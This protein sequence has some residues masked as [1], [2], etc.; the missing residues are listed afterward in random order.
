M[1]VTDVERLAPRQGW[2]QR[3]ADRPLLLAAIGALCISSSGVLVELAASGAATTAFFR[4]ALALPFLV[5]LAFREQRRLGRR[6]G[7]ARATAVLAGMFFAVDLVLWTHAINE[8]GAGIATVLGNLQVVFVA[9]AA[10][11]LFSERPTPRFAL[12]L[13]VVFAGVVLVSGLAGRPSFGGH[14]VEGIVFGVGT[15]LAYA[16]FLLILRG[17]T[18]TPHVAGPLLDATASATVGSLILGGIFGTLDLAPP[19]RALGWL[20]LLA[21]TSQTV[22]WMFITS[23]LPRLPRA[24][25]SLM[26]LLQ[27]VAALGLAALVLAERPTWLQLAGAVLICGGV[28][29]VARNTTSTARQEPSGARPAGRQLS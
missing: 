28:L 26:L 17:A 18:D 1:A 20:L 6:T 5:P 21:V 11:V 29:M 19:L 12:A 4:C 25:S 24:I 16:A 3:T 22:G 8:V 27:P 15:S 10:W 14:P 9:A 13:P 2:R 7:R 23:S